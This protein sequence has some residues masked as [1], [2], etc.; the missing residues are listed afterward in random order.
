MSATSKP[1]RFVVATSARTDTVCPAATSGAGS[2]DVSKKTRVS[3][4]CLAASELPTGEL[5]P[6]AVA[7]RAFF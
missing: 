7:T 4:H 6:D 3:R 1:S 5:K 2:I